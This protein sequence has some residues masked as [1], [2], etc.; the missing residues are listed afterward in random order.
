MPNCIHCNQLVD[1]VKLD[2]QERAI[3]QMQAEKKALA[4]ESKLAK[5]IKRLQQSENPFLRLL[6][7]VLNVIWLIYMGLVSFVIWFTA[8]FSG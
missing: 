6:F 1:P 8:I 7:H 4:E 5:L 2:R 3:R